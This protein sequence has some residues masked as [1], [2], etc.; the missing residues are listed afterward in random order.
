MP[1]VVVSTDIAGNVKPTFATSAAVGLTVRANG[2]ESPLVLDGDGGSHSIFLPSANTAPVIVDDGLAPPMAEF[3]NMWAGWTYVYAAA[4]AWPYVENAV[5]INGSVAPRGNPNLPTS[6]QISADGQGVILT[7]PQVSRDDISEIWIFRTEFFDTQEEA[8]INVIAGNAFY[9]GTVANDPTLA[10]ATV[11]Y[12]DNDPVTGLDQIESDNGYLPNFRYVIYHD[13]YWW[14]WGNVP[15]QA[16]ASWTSEGVITITE[17]DKEWF[18]GREHQFLKLEGVTEGGLDGHGTFA[19]QYLTN[20]TAQTTDNVTSIEIGSAGSGTVVI[21][22]PPS[23]LYRSKRR[24]PFSWGHTTIIADLQIPEEYAF[25]VGGGI[26]TAIG[27]VPNTSLLLLSTEF[28]AGMFT[29]DLRLAGTDDF[30]GSL[31]QISD[32]YSYSSH[33]S[34]FAAT[35]ADNRIVHWGWDAKNYCILETD[36]F[37]IYPVS[38]QV[39]KTLRTMTQDRSRQMLAHGAFDTRNRLNCLWLPTANSGMLV[40]FLICQHA[41]T[42]QW[43]MQDEQDVLCSAQFQDGDT[44]LNKIYIGTQSGFVGEAFCEGFFWNWL[45]N[46]DTASGLVV[47]ADGTSAETDVDFD[48]DETG[49]VGNWCLLTDTNGEHEQWAR[50]SAV[51]FDTNT[52]TFDFIYSELGGSSEAFD[53]IPEAGWR[54]YIGLIEVKALKY[55][56]VSMP[57][58]DKKLSELW[59]TMDNVDAV[60]KIVGDGSTFLRYYRDRQATPYPPLADGLL[61]IP[62]KQNKFEDDAS[63]TQGWFTQEPPTDRIKTFGVEIIDRAYKA[64][65]LYNWTLKVQ[66]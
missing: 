65:R 1:T 46:A 36:G 22:G 51:D 66:S 29:L 3:A 24:N 40:N 58:A 57:S 19:F 26:G 25:K 4:N 32:F 60:L 5:T 39:S 11:E 18:I 23:T 7:I 64:W 62:L 49:Y 41:P 33:F 27:V 30:E 35:R 9:I 13:P 2:E 52:L 61:N 50:I 21:Q 16:Q 12:N 56:D 37:S 48:E 14:G 42:G 44:N 6:H 47:S 28:P 54:F 45:A 63:G 59:F 8:D 38:Q 31:R 10:P 17:D 55:F 15:F 34:Q 53:P 20:T 43:F